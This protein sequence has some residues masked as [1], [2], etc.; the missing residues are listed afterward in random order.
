M[1]KKSERLG[2]AKFTEYFKIGRRFHS[3]SFT[4]IYSP[5]PLRAVA[6]VVGKK[7]YKGAVD[8]NTLRR[9]VYAAVREEM[10]RKS[11]TTGIFILIAKPGVK[12]VPPAIFVPELVNLLATVTKSR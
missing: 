9:R 5:A 4:L 8:R 2:R 10:V 1:F 3:D 11:I 12:D 6:V 7:V